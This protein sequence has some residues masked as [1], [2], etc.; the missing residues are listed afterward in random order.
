LGVTP[1]CALRVAW[2]AVAHRWLINGN[3][4]MGEG[5]HY[6][7]PPG[8]ARSEAHGMEVGGGWPV[9]GMVLTWPIHG[10][11]G[12]SSPMGEVLLRRLGEDPGARWFSVTCKAERRDGEPGYPWWP[13]QQKIGAAA[14]C[15][16]ER[17]VG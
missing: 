11:W 12:S 5:P 2:L 8:P 10:L 3:V 17:T 4:L 15:L 16:P 13:R 9:S 1:A 6:R 14:V 7:A